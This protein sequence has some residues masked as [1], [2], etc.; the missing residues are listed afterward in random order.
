MPYIHGR[1]VPGDRPVLCDI[2]GFAY[3]FSEMRKGIFGKQK[4]FVVCPDCFDPVHP[5][6]NP[7][8]IKAEPPLK[9]VG[10]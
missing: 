3:A 6:F 10:G 9:K 7:P 5:L 8:R 4:G 2:C 1:Y